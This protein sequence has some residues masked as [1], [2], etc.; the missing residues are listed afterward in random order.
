[1]GRHEG[2]LTG[3]AYSYNGSPG[4]TETTQNVMSNF[5]SKVFD[6]SLELKPYT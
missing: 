4:I 2:S 5:I 6:I 1:M 3:K